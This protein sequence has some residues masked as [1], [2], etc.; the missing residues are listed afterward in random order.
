MLKNN[1]CI[2]TFPLVTEN[3]DFPDWPSFL[4]WKE[5]EEEATHTRYTQPKGSISTAD[6]ENRITNIN[7]SGY[8]I[9][10]HV[11]F[12][13]LHYNTLHLLSRRESKRK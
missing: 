10:V 3:R 2:H 6:G 8:N 12:T 11:I 13:R 7:S 1:N 5:K 9:H 4:Q